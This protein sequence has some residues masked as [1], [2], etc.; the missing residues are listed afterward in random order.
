MH[1]FFFVDGVFGANL[2][3]AMRL[4]NRA[5]VGHH[6]N[7]VVL[8]ECKEAVQAMVQQDKAINANILETSN[9]D[10][11][12]QDTW[13]HV[14]SAV[15]QGRVHMNDCC[16]IADRLLL[17]YN[18]AIFKMHAGTCVNSIVIMDRVLRA[19]RDPKD[20]KTVW[21][22]SDDLKLSCSLFV[23]ETVCNFQTPKSSTELSELLLQRC[24][25]I[26][27]YTDRRQP[28][29]RYADTSGSTDWVGASYNTSNLNE[30][31]NEMDMHL[32]RAAKLKYAE[33]LSQSVAFINMNCIERCNNNNIAVL[34]DQVV[35]MK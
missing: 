2:V 17:I 9:Q 31:F 22:E 23:A 25:I 13:V 12:F 3:M 35:A 6:V 8:T 10:T 19:M 32:T 27:G 33:A 16:V 20:N 24:K 5:L 11:F 29:S 15:A 18:D 14:A 28:A 4:V 7:Y 34:H 1:F 30:V 21:F 26:K